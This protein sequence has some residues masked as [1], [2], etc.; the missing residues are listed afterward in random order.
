M[1]E[2]SFDNIFIQTRN[3]DANLDFWREKIQKSVKFSSSHKRN[4]NKSCEMV[5]NVNQINAVFHFLRSEHVKIQKELKNQEKLLQVFKTIEFSDE[6]S[7][8]NTEA[9]TPSNKNSLRGDELYL[10]TFKP[11][12]RWTD[13]VRKKK[14]FPRDVFTV[15]K[16]N[17]NNLF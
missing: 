14:H 2:K 17:L 16:T 6:N 3:R 1:L 8:K 13:C 7:A 12:D 5:E 11:G 9:S 4:R 10:V 15:P